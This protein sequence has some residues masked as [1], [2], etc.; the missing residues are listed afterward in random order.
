MTCKR[1]VK[2]GVL[3]V[4]GIKSTAVVGLQKL[5][6]LA[7]AAHGNAC[8]VNHTDKIAAVTADK[9]LVRHNKYLRNFLRGH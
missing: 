9:E 3:D 2:I 8:V 5:H 1:L 7:A 4:I 6:L